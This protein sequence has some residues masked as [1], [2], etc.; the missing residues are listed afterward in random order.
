[1][2]I[3]ALDK[4]DKIHYYNTLHGN[5]VK[6]WSVKMQ[7]NTEEAEAAEEAG[8]QYDADAAAEELLADALGYA[9][10][11]AGDMNYLAS[12]SDPRGY[13]YGL[14]GSDLSIPTAEEAFGENSG[15]DPETAAAAMEIFNRLQAEAAADAAAKQAEIEAAKLAAG[16]TD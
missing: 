10:E 7:E 12:G 1:M 4:L 8:A 5:L 14:D 6:W 16:Q 13:G 11:P 3:D 9:A 15:L 2:R